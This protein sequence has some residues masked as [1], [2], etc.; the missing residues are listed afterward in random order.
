MEHMEYGQILLLN[1]TPRAGKSSI[2]EVIQRDF[3]G[4]WINLGVDRYM[5]M[6]PQ[7]YQ[8]GIGLRPGGERPDMEA[9]IERMY[10][11][12]YD[13]IAAHSRRGLCVAADVGHHDAY[14]SG[15]RLLPR[16][17]SILA[18]LPALFVGI[19]CPLEEVLRR[20]EATWGSGALPDGSAP[21]P[22]QR[23]QETVHAHGVYDLEV[24]TS[25]SSPEEC[26]AV[27]RTHPLWGKESPALRHHA[28]RL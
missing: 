8:P 9:M 3:D 1:G 23:W 7:Q 2:I 13:S 6:I 4:V 18:G 20:R 15:M 10:L 26:A 11:A 19:R 28:L 27:I 24:D 17:A 14:A 16:C 22:V 25:R 21:A 5:P 12:L